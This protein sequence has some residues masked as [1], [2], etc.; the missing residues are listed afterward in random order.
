[1]STLLKTSLAFVAAGLLSTSAL[2]SSGKQ[3]TSFLKKDKHHHE[4]MKQEEA[5]AKDKFFA[6][7]TSYNFNEYKPKFSNQARTSEDFDDSWT[8]GAGFGRYINENLAI[9]GGLNTL[10][11]STYKFSSGSNNY[12]SKV[13]TTKFMVNAIYDFGA[14]SELKVSPYVTAGIGAAYNKF[15]TD[16]V[17]NST[18]THYS[19]SDW[20]FAYQAGAG[21]AYKCPNDMRVNLGYRFADNGSAHAVSNVTTERLQ[22]HEIVAGLQVPF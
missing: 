11:K 3:D 20:R 2:A 17:F 9:Q 16:V 8:F 18:A 15:T 12:T 21:L 10:T 4:E 7:E 14:V 13:N 19:D 22:S 5:M 1:M 6:L